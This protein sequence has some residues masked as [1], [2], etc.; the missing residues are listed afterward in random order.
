MLERIA[1]APSLTRYFRCSQHLQVVGSLL[2]VHSRD[3]KTMRH[4]ISRHVAP[5]LDLRYLCIVRDEVTDTPLE[6]N[7]PKNCTT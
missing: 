3:A 1:P 5:N 6:V 7:C 4:Q 2:G